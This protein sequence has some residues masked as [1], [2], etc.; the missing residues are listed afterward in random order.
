MWVPVGSGVAVGWSRTT[1][2]RFTQCSVSGGYCASMTRRQHT[3]TSCLSEWPLP[4]D[5]MYHRFV[6]RRP[7]GA[8]RGLV[9]GWAERGPLCR[10][11]TGSVQ[12]PTFGELRQDQCRNWLERS[13]APTVAV[14]QRL[15]GGW[16]ITWNF[17]FDP[18]TPKNGKLET[19][20]WQS[21][22][23]LKYVTTYLTRPHMQNSRGFV[24]HNSVMVSFI[25]FKLGTRVD[26][27]SGM[28]RHDFQSQKV[29]GQGHKV[30]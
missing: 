5:R 8:D 6:C 17:K 22:E 10:A 27:T 2:P 13:T 11:G 12:G 16:N 30:T 21:M 23:I 20:S 26:H 4:T 9:F 18:F 28:T 14:T 7:R 25:Q 3:W 1:A 24:D 29:S 15:L 19:L